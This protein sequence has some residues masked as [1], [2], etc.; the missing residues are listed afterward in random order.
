MSAVRQSGATLR[1]GLVRGLR[2]AALHPWRAP[3]ECAEPTANAAWAGPEWA[4]ACRLAPTVAS[5]VSRSPSQRKGSTTMRE[6][7]FQVPIARHVLETTAA[8]PDVV[9]A[10]YAGISRPD[11]GQL[12]D[13][14]SSAST[15]EEFAEL[16]KP[17]KAP[18]D[19]GAD[20]PVPRRRRV[21]RAGH[22]PDRGDARCH[23]GGPRPCLQRV[24]DLP[25]RR[26]RDANSAG[27]RRRGFA[28][29]KR[30]TAA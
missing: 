2:R 15:Y 30:A 6:S 12:F 7:V 3:T 8:F 14:L 21:L 26:G 27:A 9:E 23:P 1:R 5:T 29:F 22:Y 18:G 13:R 10:T 28:L 20:D 17:L 16:V 11:I 25:G 19:H 4:S 24:G